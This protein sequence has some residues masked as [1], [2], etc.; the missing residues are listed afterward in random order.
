MTSLLNALGVYLVSTEFA[1]LAICG[2]TLIGGVSLA[3]YIAEVLTEARM[4]DD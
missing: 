4:G 1:Y 2:F 3:W